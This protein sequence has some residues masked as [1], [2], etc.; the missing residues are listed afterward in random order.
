[1]NALV[2]YDQQTDSL[3]SQF[4]GE[5]VSGPLKGLELDIVSSRLTTMGGWL[6]EYPDTL[7][8]DRGIKGEAYD[9]YGHYYKN[10]RSGVYGETNNDTR[11]D[12]KDLVVGITSEEKQKAYPFELLLEEI[13]VNDVFE[14]QFV[15]IFMSSPIPHQPT[16]GSSNPN[17]NLKGSVSV[18]YRTL[19]NT[20]LTFDEFD[21]LHV[22]D[23]ETGS[24]WNRRTGI[25]VSGA[26]RNR[27]LSRMPFI[28]A[29]WFGWSDFYPNT[30]V[31]SS[32]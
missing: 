26:F 11:L 18:F 27:Q 31:F 2:M 29:F 7:V 23:L 22:Y 16:L 32:K 19:D 20:I 4:I 30:E 21:K 12:Q 13:V 5:A 25:G 28:T 10:A 17:H 15:A 24:L 6:D 14:D 1:M 8:L 9:P 3:W